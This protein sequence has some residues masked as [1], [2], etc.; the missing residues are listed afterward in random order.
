MESASQT[1]VRSV[2]AWNDSCPTQTRRRDSELRQRL[3]L[4]VPA[5]RNQLDRHRKK[6]SN[7][8]STP[9]AGR[10]IASTGISCRRHRLPESAVGGGADRLE[11][12]TA[13]LL[14]RAGQPC[15]GS[16]PGRHGGDDWQVRPRAV[17]RVQVSVLRKRPFVILETAVP[18]G[19]ACR[20]CPS[21]G[22][23]L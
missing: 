22:H 18:L 21:S 11:P 10:R 1:P 5:R 15:V 3:G 23:H 16:L 17:S 9:A 6:S 19:C 7:S 13:D 2:A 12:D 14:Q 8:R 4:A 20:F